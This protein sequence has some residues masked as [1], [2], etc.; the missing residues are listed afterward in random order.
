MEKLGSADIRLGERESQRCVVA[1]R[2]AQSWGIDQLIV[3]RGILDSGLCSLPSKNILWKTVGL[4]PD[5]QRRHNEDCWKGT[6]SFDNCNKKR[7]LSFCYWWHFYPNDGIQAL[8]NKYREIMK[9]LETSE[10]P[11]LVTSL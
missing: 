6:R 11:E 3:S 2:N 8:D 4:S 1:S 10:E 7:L 5:S 9:E